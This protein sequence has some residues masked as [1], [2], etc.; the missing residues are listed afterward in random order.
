MSVVLMLLA[1]WV[2]VS[3]IWFICLGLWESRRYDRAVGEAL[4][5][6]NEQPVRCLVCAG[7]PE[8]HD[9]LQHSRLVHHPSRPRGPEDH[10]EW[11][12]R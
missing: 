1:G 6:A 2:A 5:V 11:G 3:T 8:V 4:A 10:P 7:E 12:R 9:Y